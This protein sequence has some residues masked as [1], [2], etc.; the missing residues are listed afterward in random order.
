M[1]LST[2][3]VNIHWFLN[4]SGKAGSTFQIINGILL[5]VIFAGCRLV[6]GS[7]LTVVFFRDV[8]TALHAPKSSWTEY[9]Y[10]SLERPLVLEHRAPWWL[11]SMF[12]VSNAV[13]MS[14]SAFWSTRTIVTIQKHIRTRRSRRDRSEL[15]IIF[16]IT[17][18]SLLKYYLAVLEVFLISIVLCFYCHT[19]YSK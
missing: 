2:P 11:A 14:L 3:F 4:K 8:W 1:E 9:D 17:R 5:T 7:Y 10:S 19:I 13:L 15:N 18:V 12:M 16:L 6:W